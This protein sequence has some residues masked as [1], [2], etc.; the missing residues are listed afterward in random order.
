[1]SL[2]NN[3]KRYSDIYAVSFHG[4]VSVAGTAQS[5]SNH[6]LGDLGDVDTGTISTNNVLSWNGSS[7]VPSAIS[8]L[9]SNDSLLK[10]NNLSDLTD[11]ADARNNLGV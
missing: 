4:T 5:I 7:W 6:N 2:G 10:A 9:S 1:M 8:T 11:V 3:S